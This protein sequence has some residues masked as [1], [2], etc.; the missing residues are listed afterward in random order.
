MHNTNLY[1]SDL[2]NESWNTMKPSARELLIRD[3][4]MSLLFD[5]EYYSSTIKY[6]MASALSHWFTYVHKRALTMTVR[7]CWHTSLQSVA[8]SLHAWNLVQQFTWDNGVIVTS[9]YT[10][11][12]MSSQHITVIEIRE[13]KAQEAWA[14]VSTNTINHMSIWLLICSK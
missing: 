3:V 10:K 12:F 8:K 9:M 11:H 13:L 14:P 6:L 1:S 2:R 7:K 5:N 4:S